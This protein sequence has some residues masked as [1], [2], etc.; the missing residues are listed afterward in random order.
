MWINSSTGAVLR[1]HSDIRQDAFNVSFPSVM[2][3]EMIASHGYVPV[4]LV[5]PAFSAL[6]QQAVELAPVQVEG[7]WT[8]QWSVTSLPTEQAAVNVAQ[9]EAVRIQA[10]WQAA[11]DY[12]YAQVSGSAIGMLAIGVMQALPKCLAVQA[13]IKSIWT[14]YYTRKA[15]TSSD[16]NYSSAG[17]V[18]HSVPEL[19]AELGI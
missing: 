17:A 1:T 12:E 15:G 9:A 18:P 10:L 3:D 14:I 2:T 13:W 11:H 7:V 19:M 16:T 8:Q 4:S 5:T 6:T